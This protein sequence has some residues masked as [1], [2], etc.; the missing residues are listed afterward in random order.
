MRSNVVNNA[1]LSFA[2]ATAQTFSPVISGSG[3]VNTA[4]A[5]NLTLSGNNTFTGLVNANGS[6]QLILT[7]TNR[8]AT[9][10]ISAATANAGFV[11]SNNASSPSGSAGEHHD[12]G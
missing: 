8:A 2:N 11:I 4:G 7:G 9:W 3:V 10:N 12:L 6:G 1:T 5:G